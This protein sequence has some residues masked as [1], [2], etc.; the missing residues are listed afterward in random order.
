[1]TEQELERFAELIVG[2]GA[3]VQPGQIVAV[4]TEP[5]KERL[6]RAIAAAAY[7]RGREVRRRRLASTCTSSGRGS[8]TRRRTRLDFVPDV[9]RAA[10][11]SRWA[12]SAARA[13]GC[14]GPVAP[15]LLDDLDP[16]RVGRDQL[17]FL[18]ETGQVV[19]ER[20]TNWTIAP[21][22]T[23]VLGDARL[24]RPRPGRG[25]TRSC[26]EQL[27]ARLPPRRGRSRGRVARAHGHAVIAA[28]ERL[29]ERR[30]DA[31][32][33][34]GPGH[35]PD[36]SGCCRA[37]RWMAARFETVD[38]IEHLP[39]LPSEET[40]TTP[41]PERVDGVVRAT[42]PLALPGTIIRGPGDRASRAAARSGSTPRPAPRRCARCASATRA[43]PRLGE[44]A[45]VDR[46]GRIGP[47]DTVFYDTLL[48]ENAA[49]HIALGRAYEF[50]V[51]DPAERAREPERDPHRLHDRLRRG[52][53]HGR[54]PATA[55]ASPV[56][57]DGR[58]A[59][60]RRPGPRPAPGAPPGEVPERLN[61][62][63]W[64]SRVRGQPRPRV[65]IPPSP[66]LQAAPAIGFHSVGRQCERDGVSSAAG[67]SRARRGSA[68]RSG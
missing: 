42:K 64:K 67:A 12:T 8:C 3:N 57:R 25:A 45:L 21:C 39:N 26:G 27:R 38:G 60:L 66:L 19:N 22:P 28:A 11:R 52:G 2:F 18:P 1:M 14:S 40:F 48:D 15:G 13:S 23:D 9:V 37:R 59:D 7:R 32:A 41:D 63:D 47:L 30:F 51:D 61:G 16:R 44:V 20:T 50:A 34:R 33:L 65:R 31:A 55:G 43:P 49:S 6:T 53:G 5:G 17:P 35:R 36:A 62:R 4:G 56:L 46:E 29:T 54:R 10:D 58:L 24:S 68:C